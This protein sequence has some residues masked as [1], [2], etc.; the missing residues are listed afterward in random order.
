MTIFPNLIHFSYITWNILYAKVYCNTILKQALQLKNLLFGYQFGDEISII[1]CISCIFADLSIECFEKSRKGRNA[2]PLQSQ[3]GFELLYNGG[4]KSLPGPGPTPPRTA[5][6]HVKR[7]RSSSPNGNEL[8]DSKTDMKF[9]SSHRSFNSLKSKSES[10]ALRRT[11]SLS[12]VKEARD[13]LS[14]GYSGKDSKSASF[15]KSE[16]PDRLDRPR[17]ERPT[18]R[19]TIIPKATSLA[20]VN[21]TLPRTAHVIPASRSKD[22]IML[23]KD[24]IISEKQDSPYAVRLPILPQF[25]LSHNS[26]PNIHRSKTK[27][28]IRESKKDEELM[29]KSIGNRGS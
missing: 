17:L 3:K 20:G 24:G 14:H 4:N 18:I 16:K 6:P 27:Q 10:Q 5:Y 1:K 25:K 9:G 29:I 22:E 23:N 13:Y 12:P 7:T 15:S 26:P 21:A 28:G 19:G 8:T 2:L 11:R